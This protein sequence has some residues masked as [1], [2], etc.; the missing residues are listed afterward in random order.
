MKSDCGEND[1]ER[2]EV[3]EGF[4]SE[5]ENEKE[6]LERIK[7]VDIDKLELFTQHDATFSEEEKLQWKSELEEYKALVQH[8]FSKTLINNE[9]KKD[10]EKPLANTII[11][12]MD[13]K[14]NMAIGNQATETGVIFR[15]KSARTILGFYVV[16]QKTR[17]YVDYVSDHKNHT[18][19]FVI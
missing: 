6:L 10:A 8:R 11:I 3:K 18:G 12:T 13:Y 1:D 5:T 4:D 17:I 9:Y 15:E 7:H 2:I 19:W 14:Q 16:T